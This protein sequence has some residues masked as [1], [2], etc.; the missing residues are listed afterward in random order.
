MK[1]LAVEGKKNLEFPFK[2]MNLLIAPGE[3]LRIKINLEVNFT[4]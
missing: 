1:A 2:V 4:P 3:P